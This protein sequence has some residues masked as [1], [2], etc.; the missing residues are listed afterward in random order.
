MFG[1]FGKTYSEKSLKLFTGKLI[2]MNEDSYWYFPDDVPSAQDIQID[3]F[4]SLFGDKKKEKLTLAKQRA[5][6]SCAVMLVM[7][8]KC[9]DGEEKEFSTYL[10]KGIINAFGNKN[11]KLVIKSFDDILS[12]QDFAVYGREWALSKL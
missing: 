9:F 8:E 11:G 7:A 12:F 3:G 5:A 10:E 1:I 6:F 4:G 2:E